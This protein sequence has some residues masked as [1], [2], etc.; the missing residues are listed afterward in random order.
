MVKHLL[1]LLELSMV[2]EL[3]CF[4]EH[5]ETQKGMKST[6]CLLDSGISKVPCVLRVLCG[7]LPANKSCPA[8]SESVS[9]VSPVRRNRE[10]R[11]FPTRVASVS[12]VCGMLS[13]RVSM[14]VDGR[15]ATDGNQDV[16][17]PP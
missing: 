5:N 13:L 2:D 17:F 1:L 14:Q 10:C 7:Y 12:A 11:R 15:C 9:P 16:I 3:V 8:P 4:N 6:G